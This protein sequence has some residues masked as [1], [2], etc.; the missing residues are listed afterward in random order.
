MASWLKAAEGLLEAVDKSVSKTVGTLGLTE[1]EAPDTTFQGEFAAP[2]TGGAPAAAPRAQP[3]AGQATAYTAYPYQQT[4]TTTSHSHLLGSAAH[5]GLG[6]GSAYSGSTAAAAGTSGRG[7]DGGFTVKSDAPIPFGSK[8]PLPPPSTYIAG[9]SPSSSQAA[10]SGM[11]GGPPS[12]GSAGA[13]APA[14]AAPAPYSAPPA[15]PSGI[16]ARGTERISGSGAVR[17]PVGASAYVPHLAAPATTASDVVHS[18]AASQ[19][20]HKPHADLDAGHSLPAGTHHRS[21][22]SEASATGSALTSVD[23]AA[24]ATTPP[25]GSSGL[26]PTTSGHATSAAPAVAGGPSMRRVGSSGADDAAVGPRRGSGSG[27]P[28]AGA[29]GVAAAVTPGAAAA[30]AAATLASA[31]AAVTNSLSFFNL[32][33][34]ES[35]AGAAPGVSGAAPG[36]AGGDGG[37]GPAAGQVQALTRTVEQLRK[38]LEAS[39]LENEQLE[40]MLARAEVKAQQEAALVASLR[41]ELSGLQHSRASSESTLAAQLAVAKSGLAD[42]SGKYEASQRQVLLLEGQLAAL[43]E[44]SRR[45]MEQHN[46]REGGMMDALRAELSSAESRLAA[47]RKAHQASR[48]AAA[49]RESDLEAQIAGSTAALGDLTRSLEDANRKARALEE[50]VVAATRGRNDLAAQVQSLRRRLA[51]AGVEV[52]DGLG[53]DGEG[54]VM[55]SPG[56]AAKSAAAAAAAAAEMEVL[57]G[58]LSHH[59]RAAEL[60]KQAAEAGQAQVAAMTAELEALR[61]SIDQRKDTA[62]LEAQ[63]REVSDML[64][65]KQ[66]QLERLAAEKAAQ[67]LKTERELE[68]VRQE[69]AKLTRATVGQG[70]GGGGGG[71][72]PTSSLASAGAAHDVIPMDALG[73]PYQRLAR[74]NKVGKAVKAAAN[75]LDSTASTTSYV[76]RQ[77]PLARLGVFAYVVLIHLYVYLLIARMQRIAT[78]WEASIT[79]APLDG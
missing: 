12:T 15:P 44:S 17:P 28:A 4:S 73:E 45:L 62:Q 65:L 71:G 13:A 35:E 31:T 2:G 26:A 68:T 63:L 32:G 7:A 76:L 40:D 36:A 47:E 38:R 21:G 75:F 9:I 54:P 8:P 53:T 24:A 51:D 79:A 78:H 41:E 46:D 18:S 74:N 48:V 77:Y 66:T 43:E 42:V 23:T 70:G 27:E 69:L 49:A 30:M 22:S 1:G 37:G 60:A 20:I 56:L 55:R 14:A 34:D 64:Y 58:E 10:L 16:G 33:G 67:Q 61:H 39:R 72:L 59:K 25:P 3:S 11:L 6:S 50:E 5:P 29:S 52:E 19:S 57:R